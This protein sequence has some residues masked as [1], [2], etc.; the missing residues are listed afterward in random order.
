METPRL[1]IKISA[2]ELFLDFKMW[3][4]SKQFTSWAF[5]N[6]CNLNKVNFLFWI[7]WSGVFSNFWISPKAVGICWF[8]KH[9]HCAFII[10]SP[11]SPRFKCLILRNGALLSFFWIR[12]LF[13]KYFFCFKKLRICSPSAKLKLVAIVLPI[14]LYSLVWQPHYW[15]CFEKFWSNKQ[16]SMHKRYSVANFVLDCISVYPSQ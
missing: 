2:L 7:S 14:C 10:H 4:F 15:K 12:F 6:V 3:L 9:N 11:N 5:V 8:W 13:W 1:F 16:S